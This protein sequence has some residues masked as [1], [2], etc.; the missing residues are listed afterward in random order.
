[1]SSF[2]LFIFSSTLLPLD[3][4]KDTDVWRR[5][6][7]KPALSGYGDHEAADLYAQGVIFPKYQ[8]IER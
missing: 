7:G 6:S 1:M 4:P 3:W 8:K 2:L 5:S